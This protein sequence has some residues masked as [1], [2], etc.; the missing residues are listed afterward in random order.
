MI[1][2][3]VVFVWMLTMID[4]VVFVF[5]VMIGS[6]GDGYSNDDVMRMDDDVVFV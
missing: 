3:G 1:G 5:V 2:Y 6:D 4:G